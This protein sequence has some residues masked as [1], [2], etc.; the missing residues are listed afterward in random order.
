MP[1]AAPK[2]Y[3]PRRVTALSPALVHDRKLT[4]ATLISRLTC[5]PARIIGNKY[6]KLGTLAIG[7]PA[8]IT[9][10]DP[11]REWVVDTRAFASRGK[12]TPLEGSALKGRI[13][14]TIFQ[15]KLAYRD[16]SVKL[17]AKRDT[18]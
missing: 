10:F 14:A 4:L 11:A 9:I 3:A 13:M 5:E 7:A 2:H 1:S 6:G 17:E 8:D 12:N 16:D 18:I 15:G